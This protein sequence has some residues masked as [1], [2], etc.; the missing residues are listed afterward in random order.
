MWANLIIKP[1]YWWVKTNAF[2]YFDYFRLGGSKNIRGY[3]EDEFV[4]VNAAWLNT[5]YRKFFIYPILDIVYIEDNIL[6]SYGFG[7]GA[8]TELANTSL[9]FAWPKNGDWRDGK[10]HLVIEKGF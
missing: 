1:H 7:L 5:E 8:K 2:E 9:I 6:Y 3:L 10:L 4:V